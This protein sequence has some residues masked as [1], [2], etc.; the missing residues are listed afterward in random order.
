MINAIKFYRN[1]NWC[2]LNKIPLIPKII[3]L[4][5]FLLYNSKIPSS[6][7]IGKSSYFAYGGIGVVIH[8]RSKIGDNVMIGTN[9]TIGGRSKK[10][11]VPIIGDN[12]VIF[13]GSAVLGDIIIG[14]NVIIGANSVV[15]D[16]FDENSVV[17]GAPARLIKKVNN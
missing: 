11:N 2:F 8:K 3:E 9:C 6:A 16:S 12:V 10:Y 4:I 13:N 5:I 1:G 14:N 7:S 15:I 17:A